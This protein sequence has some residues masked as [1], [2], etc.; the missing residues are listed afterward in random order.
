[1]SKISRMHSILL[2]ALLLLLTLS[3]SGVRAQSG[4]NIYDGLHAFGGLLMP[5]GSQLT[6]GAGMSYGP[7]YFGSDNYKLDPDFTVYL[8]LGR[9]LTVENDS[10]TLNILGFKNIKF[11]PVLHFTG[12]RSD[13]NNPVLNGLGDIDTSIDLGLFVR[14]TI[15]DHYILRLRY[16]HA[17]IGG[18][19]GG[20]M[21]LTFNARFIDEE[22][23]SAAFSVRAR[24]GDAQHT[25]RY[26][27]V[28]PVQSAITG[29]PEYSPGTSFQD[30]RISL[31][32]RWELNKDWALNAYARY[33][34]LVDDIADSPII[35][36]QD[37]YVVGAYLS[38]TFQ[39]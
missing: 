33:T 28:S 35:G 17:L 2:L 5:E 23:V 31:G 22:T 18:N 34:R 13:S 29:L 6:L 14:S 24:W 3:P 32:G 15:A 7:D 10:A 21:D 12:G 37:Q 9:T 19:N 16:Y 26:F 8:R 11:G 20:V 39:F 36:D 27:G 25:G 38:H 4:D 1:M 30:V